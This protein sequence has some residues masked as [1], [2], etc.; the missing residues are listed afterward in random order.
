VTAR[1]RLLD[2]CCGA[3]GAAAGYARAGFD[4]TGV[5]IEPQSDYPFELIRG[6]ALEVLADSGFV[7]RFDAVHASPPCQRWAV[8]TLSQRKAGQEYPDLISPLR[9]LLEAT[10]LPFILENV[11]QA[12]LR[13]D[14]TLCGCHFGLEIPGVGQLR[15]ERVFELSWKPVLEPL[16]H[17]HVLPA[18]SICGHGT[19]AW[20]RKLTG[21]ITVAQWREVMGISWVRNREALTECIPPAY[22]EHV[23]K[24]LLEHLGEGS[25]MDQVP[26]HDWQALFDMADHRPQVQHADALE[27]LAELEPASAKCIVFDPPYSRSTPVRGRDDGAAGRVFGPFSFLHKAMTAAARLLRPNGV[28]LIFGDA[29]LLPDLTYVASTCRLHYYTKFYWDRGRPG[30]GTM[31]RSCCD[32]VIVVA[33]GVPDVVDKSA[34]PN[35]IHVS[36]EGRRPHPY[37]KPAE[38]FA[39]AFRRVCRP[40]DLVIDPFAGS[41]S[42]RD[43]ALGLGCR[44][45]G[46]DVDPAWA[47]DAD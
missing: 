4:V 40:G 23:G 7:S 12:P 5:D 2:V 41:A 32:E 46:I 45:L 28:M 33:R 10:G 14:R 34:V 27:W 3:G 42:S 43:A 15:R 19:P 35:I 18:I 8:A 11:P 38:V 9:P 1:P 30:S 16:P 29:Q 20:Q 39:H 25:V 17:S 31:F 44:W 36:A 6:D 24:L 13:A 22:T 26:P 37:H 21:H 47:T